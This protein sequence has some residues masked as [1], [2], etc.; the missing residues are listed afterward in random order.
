MLDKPRSPR[1][2][3]SSEGSFTRMLFTVPAHVV[4]SERVEAV[5]VDLL[6]KLGDSVYFV[7]VTNAS[8]VE[9]VRDWL[10][11]A[12][13][14]ERTELVEAPDDL[15]FTVWAE[16]PYAAVRDADTTY[17][18]EPFSFPRF[19]DSLIA[20]LADDVGGLQDTQ[21]PLY[22]QGGNILVGDDFFFIGADHAAMSLEYVGRV[23]TAPE[24]VRPVEYV[25]RLFLDYLDHER[26]LHYV[27]ATVPIPP[28]QERQIRLDGEDWTE[29]LFQS[30]RPGTAQP[31]FHIDMFMTLAG[32]GDDG[33]HRIL[34][35]D[36][37]FAADVL[38]EPVRPH[39][40]SYAFTNV[41]R[42]LARRG[43][44]VIRNPLPLVYFD[45]FELRRRLWYFAS[46]NNALVE[47]DG[48][49]GGTVFLPTYG[50][51]N[52]PEL[53]ATDAVNEEIWQQLGY[54][55]VMLADFHPFAENFG[56][57]HC[58]KKYLGRD[59]P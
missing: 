48:R 51:G 28:E 39:A 45:D 41:A 30:N 27:G 29:V 42:H 24:G 55:T 52:W 43:F 38:E 4:E 11:R 9:P 35:G 25:H 1:L 3:S 15:R 26:D 46:S 53:A 58:I 10:A 8:T 12:D 21:A 40:I 56:S 23:L 19:G 5:Y 50:H 49:G 32:R 57:V 16:D 14:A 37:S 59:A 6:R 36:P 13:C 31:I 33:R 47:H 18:V 17:L 20:D 44:H 54:R 2:V 7:V 22:F 34:V